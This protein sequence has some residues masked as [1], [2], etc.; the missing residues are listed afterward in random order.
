M[1]EVRRI[2]VTVIDDMLGTN[3]ADEKIYK[4]FIASKAPDATTM[5]ED[6]QTMSVQ[7]MED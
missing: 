7:E 5:E 6:L 3:P 2:K 1:E 4:S